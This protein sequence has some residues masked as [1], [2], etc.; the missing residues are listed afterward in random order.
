MDSITTN[1]SDER[2]SVD[3]VSNRLADGMRF[4]VLTVVDKYDRKCPV[5]NADRSIRA[6]KAQE[7]TAMRT[8]RLPKAIT[9]D[10]DRSL[11]A[12]CNAT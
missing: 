6:T 10:N 9:V 11:R 4:R 5:L 8:G 12:V 2:W 1:R 7:A 3:S